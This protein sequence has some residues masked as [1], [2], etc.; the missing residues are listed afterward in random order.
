[1]DGT[2]FLTL[3]Y[4]GL[5]IVVWDQWGNVAATMSKL[6]AA[7]L[8][9]PEM[10]AKATEEAILFAGDRGFPEVLFESDSLIVIDHSLN[11][12]VASHASIANIISSSL[13]LLGS[14]R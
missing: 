9:S 5:G 12:V 11:G 3:K 4:V 14:F 7:L 6:V 8:G 10:E 13:Q 2:V 1:M